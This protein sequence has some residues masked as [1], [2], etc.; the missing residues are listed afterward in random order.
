MTADRERLRSP[1]RL[2][3]INLYSVAENSMSPSRKN[4]LKEGREGS[5]LFFFLLHFLLPL[6][7]ESSTRFQ[8]RVRT[9]SLGK[10]TTPRVARNSA[11]ESRAAFTFPPNERLSL[12]TM[13]T[14]THT[15]VY[16]HTSEMIYNARRERSRDPGR[17]FP[18]AI[19]LTRRINGRRFSR[20]EIF[21][22]ATERARFA[23]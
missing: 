3:T 12:R 15:Y 9:A 13:H 6:A 19:K 23:A 5:T 14:H 21:I 1:T 7:H 16:T 17:S 18:R 8:F 4:P 2:R 22:S 10:I 20:R 11:I